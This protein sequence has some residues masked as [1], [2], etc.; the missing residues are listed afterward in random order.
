[1][2]MQRHCGGGAK[3]NPSKAGQRSQFLA[4]DAAQ[5]RMRIEELDRMESDSLEAHCEYR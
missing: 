1:M 5:S 2:A 4:N 3:P